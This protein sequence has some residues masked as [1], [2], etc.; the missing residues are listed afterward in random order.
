MRR[1]IARVVD[2]LAAMALIALLLGLGA[3]PAAASPPLPSPSPGAAPAAGAAGQPAPSP[4]PSP[5]PHPVQPPP[6]GKPAPPPDGGL[7]QPATP[8]D[9]NAGLGIFDIPGE[10]KSAIASLLADLL[11]P[12]VVPVMNL[13]ADLLLAT[14]DVTRI[15]RVVQL[16][17]GLRILACSLYGL[18]VLAAGILAMT[19]GTVQQR[20]H[21]R[22]LLPRLGLGM[23]AANLSL[24]VCHQAIGL[25]NAVALAVFGDGITADDL[26]GTLVGLLTN[27]NPSTGPLYVVVFALGV[28]LMGVALVA[29]LLVRIAALLVLVVTAPLALAC[30]GHPV[31]E[32]AAKLWWKT[33]AGLVGIQVLQAIVFLTCV[34]VVLDPGNYSLLGLPSATSLINLIVFGGCLY[35]ELKIPGWIR[36]LVTS[37]VHRTVG[38]G[39]GGMHLVKK[40]ALGALGLPFGP[41]A[42]GAQLAA[43]AG[44]RPLA[45]RIHGSRPRGGRPPSPGGRGPGGAGPGTPPAPGGGAPGGG[46][47]GGAGTPTFTWGTPQR[48]GPPPPGTGQGPGGGAAGSGSRG[49][50]G[51]ASRAGQ[52]PTYVWGKPRVRGAA[53]HLPSAPAARPGAL[54]APPAPPSLPAGRGGSPQPSGP[55]SPPPHV[56]PPGAGLTALRPARAA[57]PPPLPRPAVL[58]PPLDGG[59]KP[60]R[61]PKK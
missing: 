28:V 39:R 37:P 58:R 9:P 51:H 23:F 35:M 34:K 27:G 14:P 15:P 56:L 36:H 31:T 61:P 41:Y 1:T 6:A 32:G 7:I 2:A 16:W 17:D 48:N 38:G 18:W 52:T 47:G 8:S 26:A 44:I 60:P 55:P 19:H 49:G 59:G 50:P 13:L 4:G 40:V 10:I 21:A 24:F 45:G 5:S 42:F 11:Q 3:M 46:S 30:H 54:P 43:R 20:W 22:D 29:A 33:L 57:V 12:L 53:N 25:G